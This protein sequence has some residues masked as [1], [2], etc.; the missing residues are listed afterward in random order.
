LLFVALPVLAV[1]AL[2]ARDARACGACFHKPPPPNEV[3]GTV[4]TDH[5]MVFALSPTQ[6]VLWDQVRYSGNPTDFAWVLPV[7]PG[8]QVEL[9]TDAWIAA[10]DA[11]TATVIEAP[12]MPYCPPKNS[13]GFEGGTYGGGYGG[14]YG[15]GPTD[16]GSTAGCGCGSESAGGASAGF[17]ADGGAYVGADASSAGVDAG[18]PPPPPVTV[19]TQETVGPYE[20]VVLHSTGGQ[21]LDDWLTGNGYD[22]PTN[23]Q[24]VLDAYIAQKMDFVA[25]KLAPGANVQAMQPVRVV[26]PGADPSLP[27]RMIQAGTGAHVGLALWV[28]SEGRYH[29]QNFPDVSVDFSQLTYDVGLQRSNY[30]DLVASALA[31]QGGRGWLTEFAGPV[32]LYATQGATNPGLLSA[33]QQACTPQVPVNPCDAGAQ[34]EGG[35]GD[36]AKDGPAE[37]STDGPSDAPVE[38]SLAEAGD[39]GGGAARDAASDAGAPDAAASTCVPPAAMNCDDPEIAFT[40]LHTGSIWITKLIADLPASA[41]GTD[42]VLEATSQSPAANVHQATQ[43]VNGDP[44]TLRTQA[45]VVRGRA[46]AGP[47]ADGERGCTLASQR[48]SNGASTALLVTATALALSW[49]R[50]RARR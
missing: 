28:V 19:T 11:T 14:G 21:A 17:E 41:L 47:A 23:I 44:C 32:Q 22:I 46:G 10:L 48:A 1:G 3:D 50:R 15:Y 12:P 42:L 7:L 8:T 34:G 4:V 6:S 5:R 37:A 2:G 13:G 36:A 35:A 31:T 20:V 45:L 40:G 33:Y 38:A 27:L 25:M 18:P 16:E 9:S 29:P 30:T 24:P 26:E 39:D 49:M 43:Y